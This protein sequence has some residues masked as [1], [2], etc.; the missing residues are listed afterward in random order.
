MIGLQTRSLLCG[1]SASPSRAD[2][3]QEIRALPFAAS[4]LFP[5]GKQNRCASLPQ[6]TRQLRR[7]PLLDEV[8]F[9]HQSLR[10]EPPRI[11]GAC[12]PARSPVAHA[13][14]LVHPKIVLAKG[15]EDDITVIPFSGLW[16]PHGN[17]FLNAPNMIGDSCGHCGGD[18]QSRV[19]PAEI[20]KPEV[21]RQ[22]SLKIVPGL[23]KRIR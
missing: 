10:M 8:V 12:D 1:H 9:R 19:N 5:P 23:R 11:P 20:V 6:S 7:R 14:R 13:R 16:L 3:A 4:A 22:S 17:Q 21:Q 18:P 15:A 2:R